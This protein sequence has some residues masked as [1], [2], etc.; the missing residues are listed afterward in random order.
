MKK[1]FLFLVIFGNLILFAQGNIHKETTEIK[2]DKI[3]Y[4]SF[5]KISEAIRSLDVSNISTT[6]IM[7]TDNSISTSADTLSRKYGVATNSLL[8]VFRYGYVLTI[9]T[10][11]T[12]SF[13]HNIAFPNNKTM[14]LYPG[15]SYTT[16]FNFITPTNKFS[17]GFYKLVGID[18][19]AIVR[20]FM[21]G[22]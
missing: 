2:T 16:K 6:E 9:A 12:I 15:E 14:T 22:F 3:Q 5:D 8:G 7:V 11:D 13:S 20:I 1:I 4:R 19:G 10:N 18:N 17:N 21:E